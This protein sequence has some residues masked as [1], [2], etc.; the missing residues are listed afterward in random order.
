MLFSSLPLK[1]KYNSEEDDILQSF[2]TPLLSC[3][4][5]YDRA[6]GYFS[7]A[8]LA[9]AA[10][11]LEKFIDS[12]GKIR[13]VIGDPLTDLEYE[14]IL[15]GMESPIE[16]RSTQLSEILL[17]STNKNLDILS[18][19]IANKQL[20]V[21]FAF[22][23]Q[24][25]FHK[26]VGIFYKA[27]EI[28]VFSGS[29]NETLAGLTKYNS[30]E[31]SVYFSW[32]D[33]FLDYGEVEIENFVQLWENKQKRTKVVPLTSEFYKKIQK[34]INL[35]DLRKKI[36]KAEKTKLKTAH[37]PFF[38]YS[39]KKSDQ[40]V[41]KIQLTQRVP[42]KPLTIKG[43]A[44]D[45]FNHQKKAICSWKKSDY[46]GLLKLATGAGKTITSITAIVEL[47]EQRIKNKLSTF[48]IISVPYIELANQW[49]DELSQFNISA[50]KC[51]EKSANWKNS[52]DAKSLLYLNNKINFV[53]VVVVNR[54]L[55]LDDFQ[56]AMSKIPNNDILFI[57]DECHH[58]GSE[59]LFSF[60]PN[61]KYRIG[62]SATP[63][64]SDDDELEGSP[65]SDKNKLNLVNYF[66][67]IISDY[68]LRDAIKDNILAPY[69]YEVIAVYL[70]EE[71]E[72]LYE[73]L[74]LKIT[75]L[76]LESKKEA[77]PSDKKN[78]LTSLCGRR[79]RLLATCKG[80]LPALIKYLKN[81]S[82]LDLQHSLVYVGEGK[83]PEANN[84]Y[85]EDVT[86]ELFAIGV[87]VAKFTSG[88][89]SVQRKSIMKNFKNKEIDALVA[90][91]VLDEGIDV[92]VCK[93]A[94]IL[95]SSRN[96]RQYVQRRGRVLRKS[97]SKSEAKII[98][99][100][101]LPS[102]TSKTQAAENL[103]KAELKR[104]QDFKATSLNPSEV[105]IE[106]VNLGL[107]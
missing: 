36:F 61:S 59:G 86:K 8:V 92:P 16:A 26:K 41:K 52:L 9:S 88:E 90:M 4:E 99:F 106:S 33:S 38:S 62:L 87:K 91:K 53:C 64:R 23:Y 17:N 63:F 89:S 97:D 5:R 25:M 21:R 30:E 65:F 77:L 85:I 40:S 70:N 39:F 80:K 6:V 24:G 56:K 103:R 29:A 49:V 11:G 68:S 73:E 50:I 54:T 102:K 51:Y 43:R 93:T 45:L 66:Q 78:L 18:Y 58:L 67:G 3:A 31:I 69:R 83:A 104:I 71:E 20:E 105:E 84:P 82:E 72:A 28:V 15:K 96:P 44:F 48:T 76:I 100:V 13:L 101:V 60:L 95:A 1:P 98:D 79:S 14:A 37:N 107:Y 55:V 32:R 2:Y 74:S 12:G 81:K 10:N 34:G 75:R 46:R 27:S 35:K 19:L 7:A 94:Y 22:T 57:G 42:R 47:Y